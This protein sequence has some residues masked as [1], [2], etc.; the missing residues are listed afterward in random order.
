MGI[1]WF[2]LAVAGMAGSAYLG[3]RLLELHKRHKQMAEELQARIGH[4]RT[5]ETKVQRLAKYEGMADADGRAAEVRRAA[6]AQVQAA[7]HEADSIVAGAR[8]EAGKT[9]ADAK[10]EA[11]S[12]GDDAKG[13]LD[14][15]TVQAKRIVD[16]AD[17]RAVQIAGKAYDVVKNADLYERTA[18]A[19]RNIVDG[20]GYQYLVPG[21]SLLD[22]LAD[23]F[24]HT[25]AGRDLKNARE[26]TKLMIQNGTAASCDY[27][28]SRR[29]ETAVRFV[30]D[31]FNGKVDSVLSRVR[32]DNAGTLEQRI[33]DAFTVVNHSGKAFRNA[34]VNEGFL[35]SRLAELKWA[36]V[37]QQLKRDEREEQRRIK[38]QMR[39]EAKARREYEKAM[40]DAAKEAGTLH[41]AMEKAQQQIAQAT[42]E[43]KAKYEEE[44][45]A[46]RQ[47]LTEAEER[48]QRAISMAQLTK[49][50]HV[51]VISN[52]GSF[53]EDVFKIGL[54]RR[55]EPLD[56]V[57]ELGDSS[58]PFPFDVHALI[59]SDDA[60]ALEDRLHKHFV[61][62]AANK[63]NYRKEFF[64]AALKDIRDEVDKLGLEAKWT[65]T[66]EAH[67]YRET[68]AVE[69]A[70]RDDP[71]AREAWLRRQLKLEAVAVPAS[72]LS[73]E[74]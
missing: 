13:T 49:R 59:L 55:L 3:L 10:Q 68:L 17:E 11:K 56:R 39:E 65:M 7:Q 30:I 22:D 35:A 64:R 61:L 54:S 33:R 51:Y 72:G 74:E 73:E 8:Q 46:L 15:A 24:G 43:R 2:F 32:S 14:S 42:E 6:E 20:Y 41:K 19:M 12:I 60:P 21:R 4:T 69:D 57:R 53:G 25:E 48:G 52:I 36:A 47:K 58:V 44:L 40:R 27:A 23:D 1:L 9:V 45:A 37:A 16:H 62:K 34:R 63:V 26:Q 5:L 71:V 38:E 28:E 67:E 66:A 50:G 29:R 18:K 31:A 70:I